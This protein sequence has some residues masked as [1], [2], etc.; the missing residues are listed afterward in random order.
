MVIAKEIIQAKTRKDKPV[1][2]SPAT[3]TAFASTSRHAGRQE[4]GKRNEVSDYSGSISDLLLVNVGSC[5]YFKQVGLA[6]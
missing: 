6:N 3:A 2:A 4:S 1:Q 5:R